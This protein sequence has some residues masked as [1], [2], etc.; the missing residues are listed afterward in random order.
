MKLEDVKKEVESTDLSFWEMFACSVK[1]IFKDTYY[2]VSELIYK[3]FH[4]YK[5]ND[6]YNMNSYIIRKIRKP[7]KAYVRYEERHGM[8]LPMDF[9]NDPAKWLEVLKKIEFS[10]DEAYR[11]YTEFYIPMDGKTKEEVEE[12]YKKRK[13]GFILLGTHLEDFWD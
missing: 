11:E 6:I 9:A 1:W 12:Y 8:S 3:I 10:I 7:F 13:E 4:G 5:K 2:Y